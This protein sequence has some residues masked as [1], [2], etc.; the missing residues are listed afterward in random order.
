VLARQDV[1]PYLLGA[2]ILAPD[3]AGSTNL[4]VRDVSRRNH[5]F[6][7]S[8]R[9]ARAFALKQGH[10]PAD[11]PSLATE[12]LAYEW[13]WATDAQ[14]AKDVLPQFVSYDVERDILVTHAAAQAEDLSQYHARRGAF[15][16]EIGRQVGA[17][18]AWVHS[19]PAAGPPPCPLDDT[20]TWILGIHRP[21][22]DSLRSYSGGNVAL[23]KAVQAAPSL[24]ASLERLDAERRR[25]APIH[26]DVKWDNVVVI[27]PGRRT[28]SR[29]RLI[30]WELAAL[31]DPRWDVGAAIAAY[32]TMWLLSMP[33]ARD[34]S[35]EELSRTA[36]HPLRSTHRAIAALWRAYRETTRLSD[37]EGNAFFLR[38]VEFA[39]ARLVQTAFEMS[40]LS[41]DLSPHAAL[42]LQVG[43][44]VL[45]RPRVASASLFGLS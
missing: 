44:N 28:G 1:V 2:G 10:S 38:A 11:R 39:G 21:T 22:L 29:I 4:A 20:D 41:W 27:R 35:L 24:C 12:A 3:I 34:K 36:R 40:A 43:D 15:P 31:G 37:R 23:V 6:H 33:L 18:L 42:L 17:A 8:G 5:N 26:N 19:R 16:A 30:D 9:M 13:F 7:V 14:G 45:A 32:V 25:D